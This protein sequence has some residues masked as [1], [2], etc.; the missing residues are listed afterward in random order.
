[1]QQLQLLIQRPSP[2][3]RPFPHSVRERADVATGIG[4]DVGG[5]GGAREIGIDED[6]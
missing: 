6:R 5:D 3:L 4:V 2:H 1:M